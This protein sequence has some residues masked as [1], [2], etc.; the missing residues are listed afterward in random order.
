MALNSIVRTFGD[1]GPL[2]KFVDAPTKYQCEACGDVARGPVQTLCGHH[3]CQ[4]C[5]TDMLARTELGDE[6]KC[7]G[8]EV[9]CVLITLETVFPDICTKKELEELKVRCKYESYGC[10]TVVKWKDL[11]K[12]EEKCPFAAVVCPNEGCDAMVRKDDLQQHVDKECLITPVVCPSCQQMVK[13]GFLRHHL[14]EECPAGTTPCPFKCGEQAIV[15]S[16]LEQHRQQCRS[17]PM[18]CHYCTFGCNIQGNSQDIKEHMKT[19]IQHHLDLVTTRAAD[20]SATIAQLQ[21]TVEESANANELLKNQLAKLNEE[22]L[23]QGKTVQSQTKKI[24]MLER[25]VAGQIQT[26]MEL[27]DE[28]QAQTTKYEKSAQEVSKQQRHLQ[29]MQQRHGRRLGDLETGLLV[30][31]GGEGSE[32]VKQQVRTYV[33][34]NFYSLNTGNCT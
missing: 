24:A 22:L 28:M 31:G 6:V 15:R 27:K 21:T 25:C 1:E 29:E 2:P 23:N 26:V 32:S 10:Q 8:G 33:Q 7:P 13:Q 17:R 5:V 12:H 19:G 30:D 11:G 18:A 14:K 34:F 4:F 3:L 9:E 16:G 20:M